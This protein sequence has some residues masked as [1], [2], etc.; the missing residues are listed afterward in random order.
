MRCRSMLGWVV[1][2]SCQAYRATQRARLAELDSLRQGQRLSPVDGIRLAAHIIF[3]GIRTGFAATTGLLFTTEC[4]A[5]LRAGRA[6][7]DIGDTA[8]ATVRGQELL[9][10]VEALGE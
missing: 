4:T 5:D 7:V 10:A 8:I 2:S 1:G 6:D 3:P 9:G